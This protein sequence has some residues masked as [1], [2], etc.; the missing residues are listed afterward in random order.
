MNEQT[1]KERLTSNAIEYLKSHYTDKFSLDELADALFINKNYLARVFKET[2]GTTPLHYHNQLRCDL[3]SRL[4]E[5]ESYSISVVAFKSGFASASHFSRIFRNNMG[6]TPSEY[7]KE[8]MK[9]QAV[10]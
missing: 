7:R 6:I 8:H 2:T 4:L 10:R 5:D 1:A 9:K 3:A